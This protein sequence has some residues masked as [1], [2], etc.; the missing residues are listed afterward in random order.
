MAEKLNAPLIN[1]VKSPPYLHTK[2]FPMDQLLNT[3]P[4][5]VIV[6]DSNR[7]ILFLNIAGSDLLGN[8]ESSDFIMND[9]NVLISDF[10]VEF[11]DQ[12]LIAIQA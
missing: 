12:Q 1:E 8:P 7:K 2:R 10:P 6:F 9:I 5:G 4:Y 3:M 11:T